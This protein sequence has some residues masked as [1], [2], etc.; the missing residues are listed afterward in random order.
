MP[1]YEYR[2]CECESVFDSLRPMKD[3]D[4]PIAC[5]ACSSQRT[6]RKMSVFAAHSDGR[7][8]AGTQSACASCSGGSC[9]TC[10]H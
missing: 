10:G 3:A 6:L 2:C 7:S 4:A 9:A 8:V 1:V 5:P